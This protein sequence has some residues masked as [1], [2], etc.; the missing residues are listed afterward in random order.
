MSAQY[1]N[2]AIPNRDIDLKVNNA[3]INGNASILGST[4]IAGNTSALGQLLV[5]GNIDSAMVVSGKSFSQDGAYFPVAQVG[6]LTNPIDCTGAVAGQRLFHLT[7]IS[8]TLSAG[9]TEL[10]SVNLA[11]GVL[12]QFSQVIV[13]CYDY[14]NSYA[15]GG[16]P[17]VFVASIDPS[18]NRVQLAVKNLANGEAL[19][20]VLVINMTIIGGS[21]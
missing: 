11:V 6:L 16:T 9:S 14:S 8:T 1:L 15:S 2:S 17:F 5:S 7:T 21:Y 18:A 12:T 20:G 4:I 10:F 3:L 13:S 19:A